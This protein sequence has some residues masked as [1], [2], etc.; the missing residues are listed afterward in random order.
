MNR[1]TA[2]LLSIAL[3]LSIKSMAQ[4]TAVMTTTLTSVLTMAVTSAP[5]FALTT[6]A[7]YSSGVDAT[8]SGTILVSSN[9]PYDIDVASAGANLT[10]PVSTNTI[11]VT[12]FTIDVTG[13]GGTS[14]VAAALST[15]ALK[16]VNEG[17]AG[18]ATTL[19][20]AYRASGGATFLNKAAGSYVQTLTFTASVD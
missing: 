6:S 4:T 9:F 10:D 2:T 7:H 18:M 5:I 14:I 12:G 16:I 20:L 8:G 19:T 15:T 17:T 13:D 1:K 11:A 3:L